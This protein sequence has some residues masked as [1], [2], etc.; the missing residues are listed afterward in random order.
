MG[1]VGQA[2]K[3]IQYT[4][5]PLEHI[6]EKVLA[7]KRANDRL[8]RLLPAEHFNCVLL[9]TRMTRVACAKSW[10]ASPRQ[11]TVKGKVSQWTGKQAPPSASMRPA[12]GCSSCNIGAEHY[13]GKVPDNVPA[14]EPL[15]LHASAGTSTSTATMRRDLGITATR[16]QGLRKR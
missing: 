15:R 16:S 9:S 12:N 8:T 6:P 7:I 14:V 10:H 11:K 13:R 2:M 3:T 4:D 5:K 1:R